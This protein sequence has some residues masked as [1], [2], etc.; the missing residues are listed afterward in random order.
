MK[1]FAIL[2]ALAAAL[3]IPGSA[4]AAPPSNGSDCSYTTTGAGPVGIQAGPNGMPGDAGTA[5]GACLNNDPAPSAGPFTFGGGSVEAGTGSRG[6]YVIVDGD[7]QN[8]DPSGQG[9]GYIGVSGY[10]TGTKGDCTAD[11]GT[12]TN[13]GG[14]FALDALPGQTLPLP[15]ACGNTSGHTWT[16][17][18]RDGCSIP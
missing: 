12:G 6:S 13:S 18:T 7:D 8:A 14:C 3:V 10:E 15:I 4:L 9:D 5:V 11:S 16:A 2:A 1:R 17:A